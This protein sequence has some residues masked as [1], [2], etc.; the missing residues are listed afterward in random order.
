MGILWGSRDYL[1]WLNIN[2]EKT[3]LVNMLVHPV[4][5]ETRARKENKLQTKIKKAMKD[6]CSFVEHLKKELLDFQF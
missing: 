2:P 1:K 3:K 4:Q 6:N 5:Y